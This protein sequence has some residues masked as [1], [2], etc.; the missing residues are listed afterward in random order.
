MHFRLDREGGPSDGWTYT[1]YE[2]NSKLLSTGTTCDYKPDAPSDSLK[3]HNICVVVQCTRNGKTIFSNEEITDNPRSI[4][5]TV[6]HAAS[7]E[8]YGLESLLADAGRRELLN[9]D[10]YQLVIRKKGGIGKIDDGNYWKI[11]WSDPQSQGSFIPDS[12]VKTFTAVNTQSPNVGTAVEAKQYSHVVKVSN[13]VNGKEVFSATS[14][15]L[16]VFVYPAFS[17]VESIKD[18]I[19]TCPN[20]NQPIT[21]RSNVWGGNP[22][23]WT[24]EWKRNGEL[25]NKENNPSLSSSS[26]SND[27]DMPVDVIYTLYAT[28]KIGSRLCYEEKDTFIVKVWPAIRYEVSYKSSTGESGIIDG[29]TLIPLYV[30]DKIEYELSFVG[31]N[32]EGWQAIWSPSEHVNTL[33]PDNKHFSVV[34]VSKNTTGPYEES[35]NLKL[36]NTF[37][38]ETWLDIQIQL[39][40]RVFNRG[41][42]DKDIQIDSLDIYVQGKDNLQLKVITHEGNTETNAWKYKWINSLYGEETNYSNVQKVIVPQVGT[43]TEMICK[44]VCTNSIHD[45]VGS[46]DE[47]NPLIIRLWPAASFGDINAVKYIRNGESARFYS[48]VSGAYTPN[49]SADWQYD[50]YLDNQL[51]ESNHDGV[52]SY[53]VNADFRGEGMDMSHQDFHLQVTN[54]GPYGKMWA[55]KSYDMPVTIYKQPRTPI[56]LERKGNGKSNTFVITFPNGITDEVLTTNEYQYVFGYTDA[57]GKD[58]DLATLNTRYY[59]MD[60]ASDY[61]DKTRK[62]Y[63]YALWTYPDGAR[64]TSNKRILDS[65]EEHF[66]GSNFEQITRADASS[67]SSLLSERIEINGN[68]FDAHFDKSVKVAVTIYSIRG[69]VIREHVLDAKNDYHEIIS[70][71]GLSSGVYLMK[72]TYD[73][74]VKVEKVVVK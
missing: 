51:V 52:W 36:V 3:T 60:N 45:Y 10:T 18:T 5:I 9:G 66:D 22:F 54:Y 61:N 7:I 24:Y 28:N 55:N 43:Y 30:G 1:W 57:N 56:K 33:N 14:N 74:Q 17:I 73:N 53:E 2:D 42:I 16:D 69:N 4:P 12:Y 37:N 68:H 72:Y 64:V 62:Y 49:G 8:V 25:L 31:G 63:V 67:I 34:P 50:W 40:Y 47:T 44:T 70:L 32:P 21:V 11:E 15:P 20:S 39:P 38:K 71:S 13:I 19:R 41:Y 35:S 48:A 46:T 59:H 58:H 27:T 6:Y 23:G 65:A 29:N 26:F